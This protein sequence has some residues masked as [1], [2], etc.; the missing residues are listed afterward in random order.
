MIILKLE[1][2]KTDKFTKAPRRKKNAARG[3]VKRS[4]LGFADRHYVPYT[5]IMS[6]KYSGKRILKDKAVCGV[7]T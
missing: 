7:G 1:I 3:N 5:G 2:K 4:I 6:S